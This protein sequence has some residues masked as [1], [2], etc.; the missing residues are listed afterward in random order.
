MALSVDSML[1][2]I[3][4]E[5]TLISSDDWLYRM[6]GIQPGRSSRRSSGETTFRYPAPVAAWLHALWGISVPAAEAD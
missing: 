3:E 4:W 5:P 2:P 6:W 1:P